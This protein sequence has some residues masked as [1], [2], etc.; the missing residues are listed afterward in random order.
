MIVISYYTPNDDY[1]KFAKNLKENLDRLGI[2]HEI[3]RVES[4]GSRKNN[5][6]LRWKIIK[7]AMDKF[8]IYPNFL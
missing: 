8:P 6:N 3:S 4:A 7:D 5:I 2:Y 1:P